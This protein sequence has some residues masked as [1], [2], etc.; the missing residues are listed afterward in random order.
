MYRTIHKVSPID[1][2]KEEK[3]VCKMWFEMNSDL[4][5]CE[6]LKTRNAF[7]LYMH[8]TGFFWR[9]MLHLFKIRWCFIFI[10][11]QKYMLFLILIV[12]RVLFQ[13]IFQ[14]NWTELH[15]H[16]MKEI[17]YLLEKRQHYFVFLSSFL[18]TGH[19]SD[20]KCVDWHPQKSLLAS[21]SKDN[22]QPIKLWDPKAGTS[23]AT[24]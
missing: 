21:G 8:T 17:L 1:F 5:I 19:G 11:W 4:Q 3:A 7:Y 9:R 24:M 20:V 18:H 6:G 12:Y 14:W 13:E 10:N 23:L 15:V 22:Q 16:V 2:S